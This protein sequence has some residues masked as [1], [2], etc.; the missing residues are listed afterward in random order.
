MRPEQ[1]HPDALKSLL[2]QEKI[3]T[4]YDLKL[5]ITHLRRDAAYLPR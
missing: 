2:R 1:Y 3:A 4:R 5:W